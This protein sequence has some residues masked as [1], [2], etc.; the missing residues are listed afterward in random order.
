MIS[1]TGVSPKVCV[2]VDVDMAIRPLFF[3]SFLSLSFPL[4]SQRLGKLRMRMSDMKVRENT[5]M[6]TRTASKDK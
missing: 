3:L 2:C 4:F 5:D 1:K 6:Q